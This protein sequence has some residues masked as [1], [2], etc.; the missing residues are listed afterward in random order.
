[1]E[2]LTHPLKNG[3]KIINHTE[4]AKYWWELKDQVAMPTVNICIAKHVKGK[5]LINNRSL[6]LSEKL[7][8]I[9]HQDNVN[10]LNKKPEF[11]SMGRHINKQLLIKVEI[12]SN[13]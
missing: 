6:C 10:M 1:M 11:I 13:D 2:Y 3:M 5:S 12:D 4:S 8:I 9:R 7:S